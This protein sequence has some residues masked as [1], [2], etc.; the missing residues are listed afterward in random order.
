[1]LPV[2][3]GNIAIMFWFLMPGMVSGSETIRETMPYS[4]DMRMDAWMAWESPMESQFE[5]PCM[6]WVPPSATPP[7]TPVTDDMP[8]E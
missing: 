3:G 7:M 4:I 5:F 2:P 8:L 1:M 6:G